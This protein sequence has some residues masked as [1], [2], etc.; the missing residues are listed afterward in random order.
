MLRLPLE[1]VEQEQPAGATSAATHVSP[2]T[3]YHADATDCTEGGRGLWHPGR[4]PSIGLF[5][6]LRNSLEFGLLTRVNDF[7]GKVDRFGCVRLDADFRNDA[8]EPL[9]EPPVGVAE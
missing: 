6:G 2:V 8:I 9:G 5:G 3:A 1:A 4:V 7:L